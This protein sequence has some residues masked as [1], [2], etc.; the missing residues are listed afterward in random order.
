MHKLLLRFLDICRFRAG[1]QDLP[2]SKFLMALMLIAYG[3]LALLLTL[4]EKEIGTAI[5][6]A[7]ADTLLLAALAFVV[8]WVRDFTA[9]YVQLLTAM[10]GC[11]ALLSLVLW[12]ILLLQQLGVEAGGGFYLIVSSIFLWIWLIWDAGVIAHIFRHALDTSIWMGLILSFFYLFLSY[13][14]M[15]T[16]FMA[17]ETTAAV[18]VT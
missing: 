1:P 12:P 5:Q 18:P 3:F 4:G 6:M 2:A 15:R 14:L 16:L 7:I 13:R 17:P 8:L 11:L 10:A 9:R